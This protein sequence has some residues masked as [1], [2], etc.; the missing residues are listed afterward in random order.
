MARRSRASDMACG[1]SV[2]ARRRLTSVALDSRGR[3]AV[4]TAGPHWARELHRSPGAPA[5]PPEA[6]SGFRA[7]AFALVSSS[8][9]SSL[10]GVSGR[11]PPSACNRVPP[12]SERAAMFAP[13][14]SNTYTPRSA[15]FSAATWRGVAPSPARAEMSAPWS[16]RTAATDAA[17]PEAARMQRRIVLGVL[18]PGEGLVVQQ[19]PRH[20]DCVLPRRRVQ[21]SDTLRRRRPDVRPAPASTAAAEPLWPA[22]ASCSGIAVVALASSGSPPSSRTATTSHAPANAAMCSGSRRSGGTG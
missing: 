10:P 18:R 19:H 11:R 22:A 16:S 6:R 9:S 14:P 3:P 17:S 20:R 12:S 1:D 2:A 13:R 21:R 8:R 5:F 7:T 15:F 4:V